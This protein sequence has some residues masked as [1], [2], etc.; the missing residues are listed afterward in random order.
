[1]L[2]TPAQVM[3]RY[4]ARPLFVTAAVLP[5]V[6]AFAFTGRLRGR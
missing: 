3:D 4:G 6:L 5:P 2:S 1:M